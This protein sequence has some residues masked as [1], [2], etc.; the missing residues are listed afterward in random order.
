MSLWVKF[1]LIE[2]LTQLK[3]HAKRIS[4]ETVTHHHQQFVE[5]EELLEQVELV[6]LEQPV[7]LVDLE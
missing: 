3:I 1:A 5:L 2:L 6:E 4:R 7:E